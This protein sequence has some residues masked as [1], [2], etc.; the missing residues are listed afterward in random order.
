MPSSL[1]SPSDSQ[2]VASF[3]QPIAPNGLY[4][5]APIPDTGLTLSPDGRNAAV[6]VRNYPLVDQ[7][8]FPKPGPTYAA[9]VDFK[10]TWTARGPRIPYSQPVQGFQLEFHSAQA[11]I[12]YVA[13]VP[14]RDLV[15]TS[16]PIETSD[17]VFAM[18]GT[19]RNGTFYGT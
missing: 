3:H 11:R 15:I 19:E 1:S 2:K 18:I 14:S 16:D 5:T 10:I 12:E 4:W 13:R 6:T 8:S 17:S 7:P 9:E